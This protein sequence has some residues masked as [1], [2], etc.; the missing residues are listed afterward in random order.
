MARLRVT[1]D[2]EGWDSTN[3]EA[4]RGILGPMLDA[5]VAINVAY[6][7]THPQTPRLYQAGVVYRRERSGIEDWRNIP[8]ILKEKEGDCEDLACYRIAELRVYDGEPD[9]TYAVTMRRR[10]NG[11]Y[12]FH[13]KVKRGARMGFGYED[14][15]LKLGMGKELW[16]LV[17][18][19]PWSPWRRS[20]W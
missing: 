12:L 20:A 13:I 5:M 6:L 16:R 19:C 9:A 11:H 3:M 8:R 18:F 17:L 15:S 4:V 10:P 7:Q 1:F 14:P 2:L